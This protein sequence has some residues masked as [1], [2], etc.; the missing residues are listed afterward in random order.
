VLIDGTKYAIVGRVCMDQLMV[1]LGPDLRV[2]RY[3]DAVLFGYSAGAPT[4][5]DLASVCQ[6][7][8]YEITCAVSKRVP[9]LYASESSR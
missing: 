1:D 3:A 2:E 9:R 6:T 4:A 7:I 8:P 5:E